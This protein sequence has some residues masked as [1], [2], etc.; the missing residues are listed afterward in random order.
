MIGVDRV[1]G[2]APTAFLSLELAHGEPLSLAQQRKSASV[3]AAGIYPC[4]APGAST[5]APAGWLPSTAAW[6]GPRHPQAPRP[7]Q[8][9]PVSSSFPGCP[10]QL[11]GMCVRIHVDFGKASWSALHCPSS[12][13]C[14]GAMH[15][16]LAARPAKG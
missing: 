4:L 7:W 15:P 5:H 3:L 11:A 2:E 14:L 8:L 10:A 1:N 16:P 6:K 13:D 9:P 12:T